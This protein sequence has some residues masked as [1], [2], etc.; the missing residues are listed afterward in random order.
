MA[1]IEAL[2]EQTAGAAKGENEML[3]E[4]LSGPQALILERMQLAPVGRFA[5]ELGRVSV[6][7]LLQ[8]G[9]HEMGPVSRETIP[10]ELSDSGRTRYRSTPISFRALCASLACGPL[11]SA[12]R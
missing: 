9:V 7:N 8:D 4:F 10:L 6:E 3:D 2:V 11:G 12:L 1:A 5:G